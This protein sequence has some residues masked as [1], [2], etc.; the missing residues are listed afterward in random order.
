LERIWRVNAKNYAT[1]KEFF[2]LGNGTMLRF[3]LAEASQKR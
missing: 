1:K 2:N 3:S